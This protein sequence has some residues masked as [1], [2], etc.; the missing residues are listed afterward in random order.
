MKGQGSAHHIVLLRDKVDVM[1][2]DRRQLFQ[3][4]LDRMQKV[5]NYVN[6]CEPCTRL[7]SQSYDFSRGN[8][9]NSAF[10]GHRL[11]LTAAP[12]QTGWRVHRGVI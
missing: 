4:L 3:L 8:E 7:L 1:K 10:V 6:R 9:M 11:S 12:T 5:I 2:S